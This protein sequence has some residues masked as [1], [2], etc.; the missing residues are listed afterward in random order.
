MGNRILIA[1]PFGNPNVAN[2]YLRDGGILIEKDG[3]LR[4]QILETRLGCQVTYSRQ[5]GIVQKRSGNHFS[6]AFLKFQLRFRLSLSSFYHNMSTFTHT[7]Y[8]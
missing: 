3:Y 7:V 6:L 5:F 4:G 8:F 1:S 2:L